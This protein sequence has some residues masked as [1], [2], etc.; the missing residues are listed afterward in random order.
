L[1]LLPDKHVQRSKQNGFSLWLKLCISLCIIPVVVCTCVIRLAA[2]TAHDPLLV[3]KN[4]EWGY[5]DRNGEWLIKPQFKHAN[6]F[7]KGYA[8]V[9]NDGYQS[10]LINR[11]GRKIF[12]PNAASEY[13]SEGLMPIKVQ[14]KYGYVDES[15]KIV[16]FPQFDGAKD[17]SEGLAPVKVKDKWG[18]ITRAGRFVIEPQFDDAES[19]SEGMAAF[20]ISKKISQPSSIVDD[21][22][23]VGH[24]FRYGFIDKTG[25]I[26]IE[27]TYD[28]TGEFSEG[29]ARV[30]MGGYND[31]TG[32]SEKVRWGYI[33]KAGKVVIDLKFNYA[34]NFSEGLAAVKIGKK[35]GYIDRLGSIIIATQFDMAFSFQSGLAYARTGETLYSQRRSIL[36]ISFR[37]KS[38]YIDRTGRYLSG[39]LSWQT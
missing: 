22:I 29:L 23:N 32:N 12:V 35:Y 25:K 8:S 15:L 26:V 34:E 5:A 11:E 2:Q 33:D 7:V 20:G 16:V 37:G 19:F 18:F 17:F 13:F 9:S 10:Y 1:R 31:M 21:L 39:K 6:F 14:D 4:G 24:S 3:F 30:N 36:T 38:G 28:L 27:P